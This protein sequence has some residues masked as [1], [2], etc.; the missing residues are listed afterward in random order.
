VEV[1]DV[2][3]TSDSRRAHDPDRDAP[4]RRGELIDDERD[5]QPEPDEIPDTPPTEPQPIPVE[6]PPPNPEKQGPF[7]VGSP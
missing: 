4:R 6:E 1:N 2:A 3:T 7:I 5:K